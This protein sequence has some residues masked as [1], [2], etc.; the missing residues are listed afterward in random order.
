MNSSRIWNRAEAE[1]RRNREAAAAPEGL[2]Q[3]VYLLL[4]F[5]KHRRIWQMT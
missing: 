4:M 5:L 2:V 1:A 3:E